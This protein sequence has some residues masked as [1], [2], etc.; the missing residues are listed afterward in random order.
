MPAKPPRHAGQVRIIG[1]EHRRRILHF[2]DLPG[3]RP[4][5]DRVRETLFNWLGQELT[6]MTCLDAFAGSGALG[7]E[8]AS[9]HAAR[10]VLLESSRQACEALRQNR[11]LLGMKQVEIQQAETIAWMRTATEQFDV[12]FLDPPF[13]SGLNGQALPLAVRLLKPEGWIYVEQADE[14][15]APEGFI[16]HREGRAGQSRFAL[17]MGNS[18]S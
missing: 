18:S 15:T 4:T 9:R 17:L 11:E 6:G 5:P 2:P 10:V 13:A 8:A 3:L 1:G 7:F 12:V 14:I 16:I